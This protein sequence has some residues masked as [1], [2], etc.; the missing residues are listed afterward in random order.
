[1][2]PEPRRTIASLIRSDKAR[3]R[4]SQ[5]RGTQGR[6]L[7]ATAGEPCPGP[8]VHRGEQFWRRTFPRVGQFWAG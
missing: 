1:M 2:T 5:G 8:T 7:A 4:P 3:L 6:R